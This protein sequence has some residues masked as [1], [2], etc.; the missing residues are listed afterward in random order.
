MKKAEQHA[1]L[2]QLCQSE[3]QFS[4]SVSDIQVRRVTFHA[5]RWSSGSCRLHANANLWLELYHLKSVASRENV[6]VHGW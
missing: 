2:K 4:G 3:F 6:S 1:I 5:R